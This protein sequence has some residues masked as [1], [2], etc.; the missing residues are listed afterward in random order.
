[1]NQLLCELGRMGLDRKQ[2]IWLK[3]KLNSADHLFN[4]AQTIERKPLRE[5]ADLDESI[6]LSLTSVIPPCLTNFFYDI[7]QCPV[8]S[9]LV[10]GSLFQK[11]SRFD[12]V[13][14]SPDIVSVR[15]RRE[16]GYFG[17]AKE[18][19]MERLLLKCFARIRHLVRVV[20]RIRI[21]IE[22]PDSV[23]I[24]GIPFD[25][26]DPAEK[27]LMLMLA[28]FWGTTFSNEKFCHMFCR[29]KGDTGETSGKCNSLLM[30]LKRHLPS[31]Q[32]EKGDK[33][34]RLYGLEVDCVDDKDKLVTR[35]EELRIAAAQL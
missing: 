16:I 29:F 5:L 3:P 33:T 12:S 35:I 1:V 7:E 26:T 4:L 10:P 30:R 18:L 23:V 20:L 14:S 25:A 8:G 15:F 19:G 9:L 6:Q 32:W 28:Y 2:G 21:A 24:N 11:L 13:F 17:K 27:Q 22:L 34:K 31:L